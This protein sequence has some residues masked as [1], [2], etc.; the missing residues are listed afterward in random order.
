M[1]FDGGKTQNAG[2]VWALTVSKDESRFVTG[3][4]DGT[5]TIWSDDSSEKEDLR[6]LE[7]EQAL[8]MAQDLA[9]LVGAKKWAEAADLALELKQPFQLLKIINAVLR[10]RGFLGQF[11]AMFALVW[12]P[13]R[14]ECASLAEKS[15]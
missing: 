4:Q 10:V 2:R 7:D 11:S 5:I 1:I 6:L 9:N 14:P 13:P 15:P 8:V 12:V 3:A